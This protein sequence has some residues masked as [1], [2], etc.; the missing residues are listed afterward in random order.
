M[1]LLPERISRRDKLILCGLY[2]SR[3][4]TEGLAA[5]GFHTFA[6][7]FNVLGY[8]LESRPASVKNYRDEFDPLFPNVRK[9]WHKRPLRAHCRSVFE[10]CQEMDF[11]DFTGLIKSFARLDLTGRSGSSEDE[12]EASADSSFA[13]R[14][15]TGLA[16]EHYFEALQPSLEIFQP[17][18]LENTSR[19]GCGCDFRLRSS[20][21]TDYLAVEV[22]GLAD[23]TG[24]L[25]LTPKE[26]E[27]AES[28]RD[29]F[30]LFVVKN[31]REK[32]FHEIFQDPLAGRLLFTRK[33]RVIVQVVWQA[34]V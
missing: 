20:S 19:L 26:Y 2:L 14:L 31:F 18:R 4:D 5:L 34:T 25:S 17:Y 15:M 29:R 8:G 1:V 30:F 23:R 6:E 21:R 28:L 32:P 24:G 7:A 13:R 22:K 12:N 11:A 3:Y 16:A 27:L 33:E 10:A 9:G